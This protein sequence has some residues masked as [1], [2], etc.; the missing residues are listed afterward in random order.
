MQRDPAVAFEANAHGGGIRERGVS[1]SVPH[2]RDA[3]SAANWTGRLRIEL[4]SFSTGSLPSGTQCF[5]AG[6]NSNAFSQNLSGD[7]G[8]LIVEGVDD[9]K[10]QRIDSKPDGEIVI[11]L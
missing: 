11:E 3:N 1:A 9:T 5:E 7:R 2:S 4:L 10:F 6:A 8:S